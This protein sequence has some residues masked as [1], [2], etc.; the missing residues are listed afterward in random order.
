MLLLNP[1]GGLTKVMSLAAAAAEPCFS[2]STAT[3]V[4]VASATVA[5]VET[6]GRLLM[7]PVLFPALIFRLPAA[8]D[9]LLLLLVLVPALPLHRTGSAWGLL[10]AAHGTRVPT[11]GNLVLKPPSILL[12][13]WG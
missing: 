8:L 5:A 6:D 12:M 11:A 7:L 2:S 10:R 9:P 1:R 3:A 4:T 13:C